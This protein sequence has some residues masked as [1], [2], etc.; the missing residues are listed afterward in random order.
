ME[1]FTIIQDYIIL[2]SY[3]KNKNIFI[4]K[5]LLVTQRD[6]KTI[7]KD[8]TYLLNFTYL[9]YKLWLIQILNNT[10]KTK[11]TKLDILDTNIEH[12]FKIHTKEIDYIIANPYP[13]SI[14]P[15]N[16]I[17]EIIHDQNTDIPIKLI[18]DTHNRRIY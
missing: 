9:D 6:N 4:Q 15:E 5:I 18:H 11:E 16:F 13:K 3:L 17:R 14:N 7:Y 1:N 12:Y 10:N 2:M 8:T